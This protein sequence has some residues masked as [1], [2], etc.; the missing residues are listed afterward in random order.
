MH[1]RTDDVFAGLIFLAIS[2]LFATTALRTLEIGNPGL[3]GPGFFPLMISVA[4]AGLSAVIIGG[5]RSS[6]PDAKRKP[7]PWRAVVCI[8]GSAIAF[9]MTVRN[10][11]LVPALVISISLAVLASR[12][13][14][15]VRGAMIVV[16]MT[17]F[18]VLVF[19]YGIGLTVELFAS[20][21]WRWR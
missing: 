11:G 13:A 4:L 21:F 18:C 1:W 7:I 8:I 5:A 9:A 16:G 14:T 17:I 19:S 3:M 12:K 20:E 10:V 2:V 6:E 15:F